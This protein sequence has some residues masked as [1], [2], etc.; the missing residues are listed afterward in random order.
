MGVLRI[1][2]P[3]RM[4]V[5]SDGAR[6]D[7]P[8]EAEQ[9]AATRE[10]VLA[11]IDWDCDVTTLFREE[12]LGCRRAI[13]SGISW[14]FKHEEAGLIFEDD[15]LPNLDF[16][17]YADELLERYESDERIMHIGGSTVT[18]LGPSDSSYYFTR[19]PM[20][21]GFATW[22]RAWSKYSLDPLSPE[23]L[24]RV[25][26]AFR[27]PEEREYWKKLLDWFYG[28]GMDTWD[29]PWAAT[30]WKHEGI[31]ISTMTNMVSNTGFGVQSTNTKPWKDFRGLGNRPRSE[32]GEIRH[33]DVIEINDEL[34][35]KV[36]VDAYRRPPLPLHALKILRHVIGMN[37]APL[38]QKPGRFQAPVPGP[39][40]HSF[41][42]AA[43]SPNQPS[44]APPAGTDSG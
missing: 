31:S 43:E 2:R 17:R 32:I 19:Y 36:F 25:V 1:V 44:S 42:G 6:E 29:Y 11:E 7:R 18:D 23:D 12:N 37:L 27:T 5:A 16:F 4:Y 28:G 38:R 22:R 9:V 35:H 10:F 13:G 8:G 39:V 41:L 14:F 15:V 21:W 33:P 24:E 3:V 40:S 26:A 20:I 30:V 34:D